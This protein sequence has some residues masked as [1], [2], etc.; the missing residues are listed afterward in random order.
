MRHT[1]PETPAGSRGGIRVP[2][3]MGVTGGLA[4]LN[5]CWLAASLP[6][7]TALPA[8]VAL[9]RAMNRWLDEDETRLAA[10]FVREFRAGLRGWL[11]LGAGVVALTGCGS[12]ALSFWLAVARPALAVPALAVL[13]S[14]LL[15]GAAWVTV[16]VTVAGTR[17]GCRPRELSGPVLRVLVAAPG[18]VAA[19]LVLGATWL[20]LMSTVPGLGITFGA[21]LPAF[22]AHRQLH[23]VTRRPPEL[24]TSDPLPAARIHSPRTPLDSA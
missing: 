19:L 24:P 9:Q 7:V 21:S 10:A 2:R 5:L 23:T 8:T 6:L 3:W 16:L 11:P 14:L 13:V 17:P 12:L 22:V 18:R 15:L 4:V 20:A 1:L